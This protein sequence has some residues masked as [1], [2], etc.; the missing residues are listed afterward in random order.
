MPDTTVNTID[1]KDADTI[2][3]KRRI[4]LPMLLV[5]AIITATLVTGISQLVRG[6]IADDVARFE[7]NAQEV[8][9][10][11]LDR[12]AEKMSA[13]LDAILRNPPLV[14]AAATHDVETLSELARPLFRQLQASND[15][16]HLNF[17]DPDRNVLLRA[18]RPGEFGDTV[19][20]QTLR[21]AQAEGRR[22]HG[23]ELDPPGTFALRVIEPW[24]DADG[25]LLGYVELGISLENL[26]QDFRFM[27][28][29]DPF[30]FIYKQF[31]DRSQWEEGMRQEGR[32]ESWDQLPTSVY[33]AGPPGALLDMLKDRITENTLSYSYTNTELDNADR[34]Y[35]TGEISLTD[36]L[37]RNVGKLIMMVDVTD[38]LA[39]LNGTLIRMGLI[40]F[41][42]NALLLVSVYIIL[43]NTQKLFARYQQRMLEE[44]HVREE[45]QQEHIKELEHLALYDPLT[46]LPN[47]L[48]LQDRID[49]AIQAATRGGHTLAL[50]ILNL[51]R[52]REINNTLGHQAGD[53]VL[54]EVAF[55]LQGSV[56]PE[57]TIAR[58]GGDE[59]AI[60][61]PRVD[62]TYAQHAVEKIQ[63]GLEVPFEVEGIP[64]SLSSCIGMAFYPGDAD[65]VDHLIQHADVAMRDARQLRR[66][67]VLYELD[68]DPYNLRS[69]TLFTDLKNAFSNKELFVEYQPKMRLSNMEVLEA[70]ALIR[71]QHPEEGLVPPTEF[72]PLLEKTALI[73]ELTGYVLEQVFT[74]IKIWQRHDIDIRVAVN[75]SMFD[76]YS[77]D[78]SEIIRDFLRRFELSASCLILEITEGTIMEDPVTIISTLKKLDQMGIELSIDDY[79][80]GYSSLAY[81]QQFPV[82]E[83]KIDRS[84]IADMIR[85]INGQAIVN[86]TIQL[87]HSLKLRVVAEGVGDRVTW[88]RLTDMG[89]DMAQGYYISMP[90]TGDIFDAWLRDPQRMVRFR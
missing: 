41:I 13:E 82:K 83:L 88:N 16:S 86:S 36:T 4:L 9:A 10:L 67:V 15:I 19:D 56:R 2:Q 25:K 3:L 77:T 17:Y 40:G 34:H 45:L 48:L 84:F 47:R 62:P 52:L 30:V 81:I 57:D 20:R 26:I 46:D 74:Q 35:R 71:W 43:N 44:S 33:M 75:V 90:M 22:T 6:F 51:N 8:Y 66:G 53:M 65:H 39:S 11:N 5:L 76:L 79:G 68:R 72:V 61:M 31:I 63:A 85:N 73:T 58:L 69:L 70:E 12:K 32:T 59:F 21:L 24:R 18:Q 37:G 27:L 49:Q 78:L 23:M 28:D 29:L 14:E 80:T 7:R 89:C 54:R 1:L 87:A 55:R 50:S 64:V 38:Q 60:L 42:F